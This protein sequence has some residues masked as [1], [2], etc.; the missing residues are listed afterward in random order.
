[1]KAGRL[2][3]AAVK[4]VCLLGSLAMM[5]GTAAAEGSAET[6]RVMF[7]DVGKG[8]CILVSRG[9]SHV[10]IDTGYAE[11]APAVTAALRSAGA[12]RLEALIL[13]HYDRDHIGGVQGILEA[14]PTEQ[15]YLPGYTGEGRNYTS[16][17]YA[18]QASGVP[19]Q[20]VTEDV[21]FEANGVRFDIYATRVAYIPEQGKEE[22]NDNDT[23]LVIGMTW[24]ADSYLFAGDIEKE[25]IAA[26]LA[27]GHGTYDVVKMPHHGQNESNSDE[28]IEQV[29]MKIAVITDSEEEPTKK[30][31]FKQLDAA[32]AEVYTSAGNGRIT[33]TSSGDGVYEVETERP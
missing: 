7:L 11:T 22:G 9:D 29:R 18:V 19:A 28:F 31:M 24:G 27:A 4:A 13:T 17:L 30:K 16:T 32:G 12:D 10:L 26:Y 15:V 14:F 1:M 8:D 20:S 25:G 5:A 21:S 23:S 3:S 33:V 2:R 6:L